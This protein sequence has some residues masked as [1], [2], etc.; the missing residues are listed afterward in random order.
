MLIINDDNSSEI[1]NTREEY[2]V[3][4]KQSYLIDRNIQFTV[5]TRSRKA[6]RVTKL[7]HN[8][9]DENTSSKH[10]ANV[11]HNDNNQNYNY[12]NYRDYYRRRTRAGHTRNNKQCIRQERQR[13][14]N[15]REGTK[16]CLLYTSR[17]V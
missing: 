1:I 9:C 17:C 6:I 8:V 10:R 13:G 5:Q 4:Y 16:S 11:N 15:E 12:K 3:E 2:K 14:E 7:K